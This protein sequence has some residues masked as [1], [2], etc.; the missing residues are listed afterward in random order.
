MVRTP[1]TLSSSASSTTGILF[2][3]SQFWMIPLRLLNSSGS[4]LQV[5]RGRNELRRRSAVSLSAS[6]RT[7]TSSTAWPITT[8]IK[9]PSSLKS[10]RTRLQGVQQTTGWVRP[11]KRPCNFV[12]ILDRKYTNIYRKTTGTFT[13]NVPYTFRIKAALVLIIILFTAVLLQV[14]LLITEYYK[15]QFID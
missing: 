5:R 13:I 8:C 12:Q 2:C 14:E 10:I 7:W 4:R 11:D 15:H 6:C 3:S 9:V 1:A